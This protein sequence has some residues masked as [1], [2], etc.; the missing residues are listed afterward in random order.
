M[1]IKSLMTVLLLF[2]F[3][4]GGLS[5]LH[6]QEGSLS[7]NFT[8][9]NGLRV[10]LYEKRTFPLVNISVGVNVGSKDESEEL[11]GLVHIL[12]HCVLFRGTQTRSGSEIIQQVRANGAYLN[13]HTGHDLSIFEI[14]LPSDK[15]DFALENQKDI[16]FRFAIDQKNLDE[17]AQIIIEEINQIHDDP[18][19]HATALVYQRLFPD[20]FYQRPIYGNNEII[21]SMTVEQLHKFHRDYYVPS[22][23]VMAVVGDFDLDEIEKKIKSVFGDIRSTSFKE[24]VVTKVRSLEKNIEIEE[25]RDVTQAYLVLGFQGP[26]FGHPDQIAMDVLVEILGRQIRSHVNN[27]FP[28]R[29]S[30]VHS[31]SMG[32]NAL[33]YGGAVLV[34]MRLDPEHIM[35][36]KRETIKFLKKARTQNYSKE[37]YPSAQAIYVSDYLENTI[38]RIKFNAHRFNEEG[39]RIATS[40]V[41]Y[42][43]LNE[44]LPEKS[45]IEEV[46]GIDSSA[47]RK[48]AD[49]YLSSARH[50]SVT[51]FPEEEKN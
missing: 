41:H 39:L 25:R 14:S 43:V 8:L 37:D 35:T 27:Y 49:K 18:M 17:E 36:V 19:A 42:L 29:D 21:R 9:E 6:P 20:G 47:L 30:V 2:L 15:I 1:R 4:L 22:N 50:V 48:V 32:Y 31:V 13:A 33:K 51:L 7:R 28:G 34:Y 11:N 16:L 23:C 46:S 45:Y 3:L 40:L 12:E 10:F 5:S 26:E 24:K 38:N 44:E